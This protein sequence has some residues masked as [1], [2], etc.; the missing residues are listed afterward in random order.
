MEVL[1]KPVTSFNFVFYIK[2][3]KCRYPQYKTQKKHMLFNVFCEFL[4]SLKNISTP[5]TLH[6]PKCLFHMDNHMDPV[7]QCHTHES[8]K[9][10]HVNIHGEKCLQQSLNCQMCVKYFKKK[11]FFLLNTCKTWRYLVDQPPSW[12]Q[13]VCST[14]STTTRSHV[15]FPS[16]QPAASKPRARIFSTT[17]TTR[18][19]VLRHS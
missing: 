4:F 1:E 9:W 16:W 13:A 17:L 3:L 15:L 7:S 10:I 19:Q 18:T 8:I 2:C 14:T 6:C 11:I 5:L 12:W